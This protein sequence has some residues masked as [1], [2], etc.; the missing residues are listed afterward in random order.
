MQQSFSFSQ[1]A[2]R[3]L[4][5][6]KGAMA[7]LVIIFLAVFIGIFAYYLGNDSTPNADRQTVEIMAAHPGFSQQFLRIKKEKHIE[8]SGFFK[9]LFFGK[10][11][12]Y[13]YLPINSYQQKTERIKANKKSGDYAVFL[14]VFERGSIHLTDN[15]Y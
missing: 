7:G 3:R 8:S 1:N 2:W 13:I 4:K 10:E 5:K 12:R 15:S 6:N 9:R 14:V 11:D